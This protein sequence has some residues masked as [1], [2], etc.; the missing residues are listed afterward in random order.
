MFSPFFFHFFD[1]KFAP[2]G[3]APAPRHII[4]PCTGGQSHNPLWGL[5]VGGLRPPPHQSVEDM[6][7]PSV[8]VFSA[9]TEKNKIYSLTLKFPHQRHDRCIFSRH[10]LHLKISNDR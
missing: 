10:T 6:F 7:R 5:C 3:E 8:A 1:E 2:G 9:M 4:Q